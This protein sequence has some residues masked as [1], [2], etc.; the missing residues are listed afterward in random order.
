MLPFHYFFIFRKRAMC[1]TLLWLYFII[2]YLIFCSI[3]ITITNII[4]III[5]FF[6]NTSGLLLLDTVQSIWWLLR[7]LLLRIRRVWSS[8]TACESI[9]WHACVDVL[10]YFRWTQRAFSA[11]L[12]TRHTTC[13]WSFILVIVPVI[14]A[15]ISV[16]GWCWHNSIWVHETLRC[17]GNGTNFHF[18]QW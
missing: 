12:R 16:I 13:L 11:K 5:E 18:H 14:I 10:G 6:S 3:Y 2:Y 7:Y 9:C 17:R 4:I 8:R 15:L 1:V